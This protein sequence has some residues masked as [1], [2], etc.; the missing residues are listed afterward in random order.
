MQSD[1]KAYAG[2]AHGGVSGEDVVMSVVLT[3]SESHF[4]LWRIKDGLTPV[5]DGLNF[6]HAVRLAGELARDE[7]LSS[8]R[9]VRVEM[10]CAEFTVDL[11]RYAS[12]TGT[13]LR[14]P[15]ALQH[16]SRV[17]AAHRPGAIAG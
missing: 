13:K 10:T 7:L 6:A 5:A 14:A 8:G 11:A 3:I 15:I 2:I 9:E 16:L 1:A 4:G 17:P 12:A